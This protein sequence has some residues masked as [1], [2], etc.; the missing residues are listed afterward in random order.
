MLCAWL[1]RRERRDFDHPNSERY[2]QRSCTYERTTAERTRRK[3]HQRGELKKKR[4]IESELPV[5][6]SFYFVATVCCMLTRYVCDTIYKII[7]LS[8]FSVSFFSLY[9]FISCVRCSW[10]RSLRFFQRLRCSRRRR[11]AA[12]ARRRRGRV[13]APFRGVQWRF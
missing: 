3:H 12:R 5:R 6:T 4:K 10:R 7:E 2:A 9:L 11:S 1:W 8:S 13:L